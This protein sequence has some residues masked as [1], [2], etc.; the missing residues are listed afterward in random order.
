[1]ADVGKKIM[2]LIAYIYT[3][4]MLAPFMTIAATPKLTGNVT[5][6]EAALIADA[7]RE[8]YDAD[9][10]SLRQGVMPRHNNR[11]FLICEL[12]PRRISERMIAKRQIH[13]FA[14]SEDRDIDNNN[15]SFHVAGRW[16]RRLNERISETIWYAYVHSDVKVEARLGNGVSEESA[17][18]LAE[19]FSKKPEWRL[20]DT[21]FPIDPE[22]KGTTLSVT[23][24]IEDLS[25]IET[26]TPPDYYPKADQWY[27]VLFG[28]N[29]YVVSRN[30][31]NLQIHIM[32]GR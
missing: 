14:I 13:Y 32:V 11:H 23:Q 18:R 4:A 10:I 8:Q 5:K 17:A 21:F 2:K 29:G 25:L 16:K 27:K 22:Y 31:D 3:L 7:V 26:F 28:R 19:F 1:M 12:S 6:E 15:A 9:T 30:G 20:D 24:S